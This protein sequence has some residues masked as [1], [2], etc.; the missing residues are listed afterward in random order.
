MDDA[1]LRSLMERNAAQHD[2]PV[3][4]IVRNSLL[5]GRRLEYRQVVQPEPAG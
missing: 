5:A 2:P 1:S 4:A 3:A